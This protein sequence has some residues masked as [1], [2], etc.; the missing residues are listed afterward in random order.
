MHA[1]VRLLTGAAYKA[2]LVPEA[3]V[4]TDQG[5]KCVFVVSDKNLVERRP[6]TL[7][8]PQDGMRVVK[9]GLTAGDWVIV[10]SAQ[11]VEPGKTVR[12]KKVSLPEP[13]TREQP[14]GKQP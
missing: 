11:G 3:A 12:P 8:M 4:G 1:R 10:K 9:E 6:V 13:G 5:Q 14:G 2:L 7:G